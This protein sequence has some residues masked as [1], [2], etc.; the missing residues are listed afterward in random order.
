[1]NIA[2]IQEKI[3]NDDKFVISEVMK[4]VTYY[5]LKHTLRWDQTHTGT[6]VR[7]SV[8][9]HIFG[10]HIL[11]DYFLPFYP[12]LDS[13]GVRNLVTWHD[14]AE[15]LVGDM[16]TLS[17][18]DAHKNAE[19]A[20]EQTLANTA[21]ELLQEKIRNL[22]KEY[23]EQVTPEAKFVKAIDKVEPFLHIFFL[24]KTMQLE[25]NFTKKELSDDILRR[26]Q[27]NRRKYLAK[28][29]ILQRLDDVLLPEILK[30]NYI[31]PE[32]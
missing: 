26:Y 16:T 7:E 10:M 2:E 18:T 3:L 21:P 1:M 25:P 11:C 20:A 23:N 13:I 8:A 15:A 32:A 4:L 9:E 19:L 29:D 17:K 12:E 27:V 6:D 31:N 24:T 28:F 30:T 22:F 14:M 5:Q